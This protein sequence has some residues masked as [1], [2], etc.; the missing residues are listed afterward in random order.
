MKRNVYGVQE[1]TYN[2]TH[3]KYDAVFK[4]A[5]ENWN[6]LVE[7]ARYDIYGENCVSVA[8]QLE[9]YTD[10]PNKVAQDIAN[11]ISLSKAICGD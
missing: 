7:R 2:Y 4:Y 3:K 10:C 8:D 11:S 9:A 1:R 5:L 6:K